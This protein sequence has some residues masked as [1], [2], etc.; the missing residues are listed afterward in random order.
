M[1]PDDGAHGLKTGEFSNGT[2]G[3]NTA[4]T[5]TVGLWRV[6]VAATGIIFWFDVLTVARMLFGG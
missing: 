1:P 5:H 2:S 6:M 4:G 3:E